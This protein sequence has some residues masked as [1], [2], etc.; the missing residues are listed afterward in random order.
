MATAWRV[1]VKDEPLQLVATRDIGPFAAQ[2][3]LRPDDFV[4]RAISLAGVEPTLNAANT[5]LRRKVGHAMPETFHFLV[6]FIRLMSAE[7]GTMFR[8]FHSEGYGANISAL[9][10]EYPGMT[11]FGDWIE[12]ESGWLKKSD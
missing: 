8:W 9:R 11:G 6:R 4:G 5:T 2:E 10:K 3:F 12:V 1:A 7:C